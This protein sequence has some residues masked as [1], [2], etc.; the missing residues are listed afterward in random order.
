MTEGGMTKEVALCKQRKGLK[1]D[2]GKI[3]SKKF[4]KL[5]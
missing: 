3:S 5:R 4:F 1:I 2:T